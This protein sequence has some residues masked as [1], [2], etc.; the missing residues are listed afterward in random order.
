M[1]IAHISPLIENTGGHRI[2]YEHISHLRKLGHQV[3]IYA[4]GF[5][6]TVS[7]EW[8]TLTNDINYFLPIDKLPYSSNNLRLKD[9]YDIVIANLLGGAENCLSI[10]HPNKVYF[11]QNYDPFIFKNSSDKIRK[12]HPWE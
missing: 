5:H 11:Y 6:G 10:N 9:D 8:R 1:K 2:L 7:E 3:D 4:T 12:S